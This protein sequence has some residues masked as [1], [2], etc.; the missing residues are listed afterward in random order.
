MSESE[1]HAIANDGIIF[2]AEDAPAALM[3]GFRPSDP[4]SSLLGLG[5]LL[6]RNVPFFA[7]EVRERALQCFPLME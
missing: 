6:Q 7:K 1:S 3:Q 4:I 5:V 2:S